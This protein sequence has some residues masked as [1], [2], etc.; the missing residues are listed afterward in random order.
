MK[1]VTGQHVLQVAEKILA[2]CDEHTSSI[3][4]AR[5]AIQ[6]ADTVI[7]SRQAG[8]VDA[9]CSEASERSAVAR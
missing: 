6:V 3:S 2:V 4:A 7:A 1:K 8:E 5:A 9:L